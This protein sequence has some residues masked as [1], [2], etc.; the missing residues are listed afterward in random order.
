VKN[1]S[2]VTLIEM[3]IVVAL[4]GLLAGVTFPAASSGIDSLRLTSA[5]SSVVGLFNE[6]LIRA[7]RRQQVVELTISRTERALWLRSSEPGFQKRVDLPT[8]VSILSILPEALQGEDGSR[9]FLLFPGGAVPGLEIAMANARNARR[10][11]RLDPITG[12]ASV[13]QVER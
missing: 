3:L 6:A 4:I 10:V 13:V 12:V 2:G 8:G 1:S 9:R 7:E 11:V 5:T